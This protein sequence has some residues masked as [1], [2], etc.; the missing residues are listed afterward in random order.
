MTSIHA[1]NV[2]L[3]A[4]AMGSAAAYHL[5]KRGE[6]VLL[7][8]QFKL[9]HERGSSHGLARITRHSYAN[10]DYA[11]LMP[12]AFRA[13]RTLEADAGQKLGQPSAGGLLADVGAPRLSRRRAVF[14]GLEPA[15]DLKTRAC[16]QA[17]GDG[18]VG[19]SRDHEVSPRPTSPA[20]RARHDQ[21]LSAS[22]IGGV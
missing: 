12:E 7:I 3:G 2:V 11:K 5:A 14:P 16:G 17:R 6:S 22:G 1:N 9:G 21:R 19:Q 13:W 15:P 10:P 4:G 20:K 18:R 8:E